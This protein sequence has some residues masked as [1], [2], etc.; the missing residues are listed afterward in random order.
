MKVNVKR[1]RSADEE[2]ADI[3]AAAVTAVCVAVMIRIYGGR[4][5]RE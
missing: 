3:Y 5:R 2:H 4:Y 1:V